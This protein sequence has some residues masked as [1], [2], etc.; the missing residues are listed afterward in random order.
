MHFLGGGRDEKE[1]QCKSMEQFTFLEFGLIA[2]LLELQKLP[3][4]QE[5]LQ[6]DCDMLD[7]E[8]GFLLHFDRM[9]MKRSRSNGVASAPPASAVFPS[10][11]FLLFLAKEST[12]RSIIPVTGR[13][14]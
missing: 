11:A 10:C 7:L 3:E 9:K 13:R 4:L 14:S 6:T 8:R 1:K 12:A 5:S 2:Q